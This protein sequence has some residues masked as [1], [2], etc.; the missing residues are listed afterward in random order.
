MGRGRVES[1]WRAEERA[2][3]EVRVGTL[4]KKKI[5]TKI[6][7]GGKRERNNKTQSSMCALGEGALQNR[8][9]KAAYTK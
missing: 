1:G 2:R 4:C 6:S 7:G 3:D 5:R 9:G 8:K